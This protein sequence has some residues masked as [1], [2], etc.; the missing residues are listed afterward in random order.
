MGLPGGCSWTKN[1]LQF[2]NS[3]YRR[4]LPEEQEKHDPHVLA[5]LAMENVVSDVDAKDF[6]TPYK[7]KNDFAHVHNN[8]L[9][10]KYNRERH[11]KH[12]YT[13]SLLQGDYDTDDLSTNILTTERTSRQ[14]K[15]IYLYPTKDHSD[16]SAPSNVPTAK[17]MSYKSMM[18]PDLVWLPTDQ[19]LLDCPEYRHIFID[20]ALNQQ[21]W[22][23]DYS[24][25][26]KKMVRICVYIPITKIFIFI[27]MHPC[28][29]IQIF[30]FLITER[31]G[32]QV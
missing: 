24:K 6:L 13:Q 3:Y 19:A 30:A 18:Q 22:F 25:A 28:L 32:S 8:I 20:Y 2:D 5:Q 29:I 21:K 4:C 16:L 7:E 10:Q 9:I 23:D 17:S 1:W 26:H 14:E 12:R 31:D 11:A 27:Y 15:N